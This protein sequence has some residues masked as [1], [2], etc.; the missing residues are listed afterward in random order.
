MKRKA[1][2]VSTVSGFIPQFEMNNVRILQ[3][4]G[5][6]VHYASN[7]HTPSYGKDNRRLDGTGIIRHQIDFVRSPY[8]P[9]NLK[10]YRQLKALMKRECFQLVHC[11]TPMG[12][13]MARLA[14]KATKTKPIIYTAHG[15]HFFKG[16]PLRNWLF[17]YP[18]ERWLSRYTTQ[19][20]CINQEDFERAQKFHAPYVD[21]IPGAGINLTKIQQTADINRKQK[22]DSMGLPADKKIL[23]SV[24][25]LIPRKNHETA[26]RAFAKW[27]DSSWLYLICGQ[28]ELD[29]YL[30]KLVE[31][32]NLEQQVLFLGYRK[33]VLEICR[34][35][36][37]F[38]FPS[39]QEGLPMAMLEAMACGLPVICSDVRG[40]RDLMG[41]EADYDYKDANSWKM[42]PGGVM[43]SNANDI[44]G[45][46]NAMEEMN[47]QQKA[48]ARW[49]KRNEN[50][51]QGYAKEIVQERISGIYCRLTDGI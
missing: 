18:V 49:G 2:L 5:Y 6:E 21:Y 32:L 25:E 51:A 45:F 46:S 43:V 15:F 16:A 4:M 11:H 31:E 24:G 37:C 48:W 36:D 14:G 50:T 1:L 17:Y 7:Y 33:D 39:F 38:L 35:S 28:G 30:K 34:I 9:A 3:E 27:R 47:K 13:V 23:L 19:L 44:E 42:T 29:E 8:K 10:V 12:A 20:I 22:R 41:A 26:I 40:N